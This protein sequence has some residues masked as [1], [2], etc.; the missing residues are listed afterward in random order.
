MH[1]HRHLLKLSTLSLIA[2]L[3]VLPFGCKSHD[4]GSTQGSGS[5]GG[6]G[7][8][9]SA[10]AGSGDGTKPPVVKCTTKETKSGECKSI[11]EG[12]FAIKMELDVWW[13]DEVNNTPLMDPGRG[14]ITLYYRNTT[15]DFCDDGS[16]GLGTLH[17][18]GTTL[19]TFVVD[20][21]C[22][23]TKITFPDALWDKPGIPDY[24]TT[25]S[26]TGFDPGDMLSV[27][28]R[29][30]LLGIELDDINGEWPKPS[31][32]V[33][34]AC[35]SGKG[36]DCFP[37]QDGDD[38]PGITVEFS[39][40]EGTYGEAEGAPY[41]CSNGKEFTYRS[42][43]LSLIGAATGAKGAERAF[44]GL[45]L[46]SGADLEIS[47]DCKGGTGQGVTADSLPSRVV[48]CVHEPDA[49]GKSTP[50][51]EAEALFVDQNTPNY[52]VLKEGEVPPATWLLPRE[53]AKDGTK[54]PDVNVL[55]RSKSKGT[56]VTAIRLADVGKD[57][58]CEDVRA[59]EFPAFE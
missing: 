43:P 34:F 3:Q 58:S 51:T 42:A 52:H 4:E 53:R 29:T 49:S 56:R 1:S 38:N 39:P 18:C 11:A 50:C 32:T 36:V 28:K 47:S 7:S 6:A 41:K 23:A 19:P 44:V 24:Y 54:K 59:A 22:K 21:T 40:L 8:G 9:G 16:S 20:T 26:V 55:D 45:R 15:S 31:E 13:Q 57:I 17:P 33:T 14:K 46:S 12:I 25:G 10:L 5:N 48:D 35:K 27:A 37:D 2:A 30:F